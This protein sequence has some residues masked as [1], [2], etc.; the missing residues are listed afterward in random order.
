MNIDAK[1]LNKMLANRIQQHT[2][3]FTCHNQVVFV[4]VRQ[5]FFNMHKAI[6]A[7]HNI[8]ILN[9]KCI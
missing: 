9:D 4:P 6:N 5:I 3:S 8:N 1:I 2:K 7:I